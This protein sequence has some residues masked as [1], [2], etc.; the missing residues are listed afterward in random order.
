[1]FSV[2]ITL[3]GSEKREGIVEFLSVARILIA[4]QK[5]YVEFM[6]GLKLGS[7]N[8]FYCV[9]ILKW[10]EKFIKEPCFA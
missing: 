3:T 9:T 7:L 6:R 8:A 2:V 1:M 4:R 5:E 10:W